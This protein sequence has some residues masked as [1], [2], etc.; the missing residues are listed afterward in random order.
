MLSAGHKA[1]AIPSATLLTK[2]EAEM[3]KDLEHFGDSPSEHLGDSPSVI[4]SAAHSGDSPRAIRFHMFHYR[5]SSSFLIPIKLTQ[6]E[7]V[8]KLLRLRFPRYWG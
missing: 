7:N 1:I 2:K 4:R 5:F 3:L 6:K 8:D